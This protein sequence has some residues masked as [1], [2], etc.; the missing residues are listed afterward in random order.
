MNPP[1]WLF[2]R[3]DDHY[4]GLEDNERL[5]DLRLR[6]GETTGQVHQRT[7]YHLPLPHPPFRDVPTK[8]RD[9]GVVGGGGLVDG[10][11]G[12]GVLVV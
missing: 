2:P 11:E 4:W 8:V 6:G 9:L 3:G 1:P 7:F 12:V 10:V 5:N